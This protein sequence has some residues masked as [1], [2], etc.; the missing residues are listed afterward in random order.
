METFRNC[1]NTNTNYN[2]NNNNSNTDFKQPK[3][4]AIVVATLTW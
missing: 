3:S 1:N 2:N 4:S